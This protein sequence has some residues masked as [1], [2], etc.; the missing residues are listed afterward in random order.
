MVA[1][2]VSMMALP[3]LLLLLL[4]C[5]NGWER[6]ED[7][8]ILESSFLLPGMWRRDGI[9]TDPGATK[10]CNATCKCEPTFSSQ[11]L[12]TNER[13]YVCTYCIHRY[14]QVQREA[15][16]PLFR[17]SNSNQPTSQQPRRRNSILDG[18]TIRKVSCMAS[19]TITNLCNSSSS[20]PHD[21]NSLI[22]VV[23]SMT[24][25]TT[26]RPARS[27]P[28]D[29]LTPVTRPYSFCMA[30]LLGIYLV[31]LLLMSYNESYIFD[32][33]HRRRWNET[34]H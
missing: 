21:C 28:W 34:P 15:R 10:R 31:G 18:H 19:T 24:T 14:E 9:I 16:I 6:E 12:H 25:T 4:L 5:N 13:L 7:A 1:V 17:S 26:S 32:E 8:E 23:I 2:G 33:G 22:S 29:C 30:A 11:K 20:S 27:A 3:L